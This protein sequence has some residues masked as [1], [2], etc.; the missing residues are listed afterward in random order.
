VSEVWIFPGQGS[1][2]Q[3]MGQPLYEASDNASSILQK[4]EMLAGL[5]LDRIMKQGPREQLV[6][7][8]VLEPAL[9]ALQIAYVE[10]LRKAGK[11]PDVVAGYSLGELAAFYCAEVLSLDDALRIAVL[12]SRILQKMAGES[13][14]MVTVRGLSLETVEEIV[15]HIGFLYSIAVAAHNAPRHSAITG[16]RHGVIKAEIK[17]FARG[18]IT[19]AVEVAGPWHSALAADCTTEVRAALADFDFR[20]PKLPLY[21]S[22]T[23]GL[24]TSEKELRRC[25]AEQI[26]LPVLWNE[27]LAELWKRGAR[28]SLEIGPGH[29]LTGF[30]RRV[31]P[32][33]WHQAR[34]LERESG[35]AILCRDLF[36]PAAPGRA[37]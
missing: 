16:E 2:Y 9:V 1:Q 22:A 26:S 17:A 24:V 34:F 25:L 15:A 6:Q 19:A 32:N 8:V 21:S 5:P 14:R 20:P 7:P 27:V 23:G 35:S 28:S 10:E 3:G 11:H 4:A 12:R 13:W 31:W 29:V 33:G 18:G 37:A 30:V 36:L